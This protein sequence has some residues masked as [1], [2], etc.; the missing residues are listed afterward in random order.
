MAEERRRSSISKENLFQHSASGTEK[1]GQ[2][3]RAHTPV[4]SMRPPPRTALSDKRSQ[5]PPTRAHVERAIRTRSPHPASSSPGR[6]YGLSLD[7]DGDVSPQQRSG[8][9]TPVDGRQDEHAYADDEGIVERTRR[10]QHVL[11]TLS[12]LCTGLGLWGVSRDCGLTP[13]L[14]FPVTLDGLTRCVN[15]TWR[16]FFVLAARGPE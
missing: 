2:R 10:I 16:G 1:D 12:A 11:L 4:S 9:A 14:G 6:R 7:S 5:R 13:S 8:A 3:S 15:A